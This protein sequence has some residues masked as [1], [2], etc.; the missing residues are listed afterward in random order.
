MRSWAAVKAPHVDV[1]LSTEMFVNY[2]RAKAGRDAS[3]VDWLATWKNWLLSDEQKAGTKTGRAMNRDEENM[4]V[5]AMLAA[6]E[7]EQKG[8]AG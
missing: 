6:R 3:K 2:W 7:A 4:S 5:V 1:N 8:I